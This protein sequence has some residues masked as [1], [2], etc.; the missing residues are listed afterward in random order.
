ML[1]IYEA[2]I[3]VLASSL[4][5]VMIGTTVGFTMMMQTV[6]FQQIPLVFYFP[7]FHFIIISCMSI[8]CAFLSTWGPS[9]QLLKNEIS[10]IFRLGGWNIIFL[11]IFIKFTIIQNL[12]TNYYNLCLITNYYIFEI[13]ILWFKEWNHCYMYIK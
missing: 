6:L 8:I 9:R 2:F 13:F 3:L 1:Y 7:W 11:L 12:P 10:Y 4:L 5:G